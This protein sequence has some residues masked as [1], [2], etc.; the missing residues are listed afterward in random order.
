MT[1]EQYE[2][3]AIEFQY[4]VVRI[5]DAVLAGQ[6]IAAPDR[7]DICGDLSFELAMLFDEA[8]ISV[9]GEEYQPALCFE[10]DGKLSMNPGVSLHES[11]QGVSSG[12]F[13]EQGIE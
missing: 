12:Y 1:I 10:R 6:K 8:A 7:S 9:G 11:A 3:L 13:E 2:E 4:R 5:V